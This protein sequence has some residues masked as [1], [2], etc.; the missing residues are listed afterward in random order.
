MSGTRPPAFG[1]PLTLFTLSTLLL[2]RWEREGREGMGGRSDFWKYKFW[3]SVYSVMLPY[4]SYVRDRGLTQFYSM[5]VRILLQY[6]TV[7]TELCYARIIN[8]QDYVHVCRCRC[9]NC[10]EKTRWYFDGQASMWMPQFT[11]ITHSNVWP[12][13]DLDFDPMALKPNQFI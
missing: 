4:C 11:A 6:Y 2:R 12:C 10:T 5:L 9:K 1:G 7:I 13:C 3:T 8:K